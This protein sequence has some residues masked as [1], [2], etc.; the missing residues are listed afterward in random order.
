[1]NWKVLIKYSLVLYVALVI[2]G[3]PIGYLMADIDPS[4]VNVPDWLVAYKYS[5]AFLIC[6]VG[7]IYLTK[8][9]NDKPFIHGLFIVFI[10]SGISSA[11]ELLI[12]PEIDYLS[13]LFDLLLILCSLILG[14][15][16]MILI[17]KLK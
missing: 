11:F 14:A 4:G 13:W 8:T 16:F 9:E 1:M 2:S 12:F 5:A 6:F 17:K 15:G 7:F 10:I 3:I